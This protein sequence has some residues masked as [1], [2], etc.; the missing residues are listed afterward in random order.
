MSTRLENL[1]NHIKSLGNKWQ[2]DGGDRSIKKIW[3]AGRKQF[4]LNFFAKFKYTVLFESDIE[5]IFDYIIELD[6]ELQVD[7]FAK[8]NSIGSHGWYIFNLDEGS[9]VYKYFPNL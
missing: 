2:P 1:K 7:V 8:H 9:I 6:D 3:D 4:N 5:G